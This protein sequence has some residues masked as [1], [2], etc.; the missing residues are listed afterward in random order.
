MRESRALLL[1]CTLLTFLAA[2]DASAQDSGTLLGTVTNAD[3]TPLHH[4]RVRLLATSLETESSSDG[5]FRLSGIPSGTYNIELRLIGFAVKIQPVTIE[6]GGTLR[7]PIEMAASATPID[8]VSVR[9]PAIPPHLRDFED[10]R[11]RGSGR[12]FTRD[13][14]DKMHARLVTDILRRVP[15]FQFQPARSDGPSVQ[16]GRTG[17]RICPIMYYVN[18]SPFPVGA[19]QTINSF[20]DAATVD[21]V[22]VYSGSSSVPA[23]FNST[24]YN[25]RCG[26]VVIWT[27]QG[28]DKAVR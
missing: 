4:V 18:G 3:K 12:Y 26:V 2:R 14:I 16:T 17:T 1:C 6:R 19:D 13:Q 11:A 28:R 5:T 15:G 7:L 27:R 8:T 25:T 9:A 20:V 21:A 10:R 24:M 23:Q 22:E